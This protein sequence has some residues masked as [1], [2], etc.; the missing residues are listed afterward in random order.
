MMVYFYLGIVYWLFVCIGCVMFAGIVKE[1]LIKNA[2]NVQIKKKVIS[3][4][5]IL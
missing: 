2:E 1:K 5:G 4:S 3:R